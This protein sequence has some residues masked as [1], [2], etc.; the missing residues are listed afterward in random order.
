MAHQAE[1]LR[2]LA[3]AAAAQQRTYHLARAITLLRQNAMARTLAEKR[4]EAEQQLQQMREESKGLADALLQVEYERELLRLRVEQTRRERDE[5]SRVSSEEALAAAAIPAAAQQSD[6]DAAAVTQAR[7]EAEAVEAQL[8]KL[9]ERRSRAEED[10]ERMWR[11]LLAI[12]DNR[13]H[14]K[15][16][17]GAQSGGASATPPEDTRAVNAQIAAVTVAAAGAREAQKLLASETAE[18]RAHLIGVRQQLQELHGVAVEL[19]PQVAAVLNGVVR[20]LSAA[21]DACSAAQ[22]AQQRQRLAA[23]NTTVAGAMDQLRRWQ[24]GDQGGS[25]AEHEVRNT[26]AR[27]MASDAHAQLEELRRTQR[28]TQQQIEAAES[29]LTQLNR[30]QKEAQQRVGAAQDELDRLRDADAARAVELADERRKADTAQE[31][32]IAAVTAREEAETQLAGARADLS[33]AQAELKKVST[34]APAVQAR[35]AVEQEATEAAQRDLARAQQVCSELDGELTAAGEQLLEAEAQLAEVRKAAEAV[36][37][38][39]GEQQEAAKTARGDLVEAEQQRQQLEGE[40]SAARASL[41]AAETQVKKTRAEAE[42]QQQAAEREVAAA[43]AARE[44]LTAARAEVAAAEAELTQLPAA[45]AAARTQAQQQ[46]QA[47]QDALAVVEQERERMEGELA[48]ARD[49]LLTATTQLQ[50]VQAQRSAVE[51]Q[52]VAANAELASASGRLSTAQAQLKKAEERRKVVCKQAA[53]QE[54]MIAAAE[55]KLARLQEMLAEQQRRINKAHVTAA[56]Q[57]ASATHN[58]DP[59]TVN[60]QGGAAGGAVPAAAA[61][62]AAAV[63]QQQIAP[64]HT[65]TVDSAGDQQVVLPQAAAVQALA[66]THG[67]TQTDSAGTHGPTTV[68]ER[69]AQGKAVTKYSKR[70]AAVTRASQAAAAKRPR[71]DKRT[72]TASGDVDFDVVDLTMDDSS[73]ETQQLPRTS[74]GAGQNDQGHRAAGDGGAEL[75]RLGSESAEAG[76]CSAAH[77]N[78]A[79][80]LQACEAETGRKSD[81]GNGGGS[82]G[83]G[84]GD[85]SG[86]GGAARKAAG[87]TGRGSGSGDGGNGIAKTMAGA[88]KVSAAPQRQGGAPGKKRKA[89]KQPPVKIVKATTLSFL[90]LR[91]TPLRAAAAVLGRTPLPVA[92][93]A[94]LMGAAVAVAAAA[95]AAATA[96]ASAAATATASAAA[97]AAAAKAIVTG[98]FVQTAQLQL[99]ML[100]H[101]LRKNTGGVSSSGNEPGAVKTRG[102]TCSPADAAAG[103]SAD[104]AEP[105]VQGDLEVLAKQAAKAQARIK[106]HSRLDTYQKFAVV[107]RRLGALLKRHG[108]MRYEFSEEDITAVAACMGV[109][110]TSIMYEFTPASPAVPILEGGEATYPGLSLHEH[111]GPGV[112][113]LQRGWLVHHELIP[114]KRPRPL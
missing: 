58:S 34:A 97:T 6:I 104:G 37:K 27:Q 46:R 81:S 96:T 48:A 42:E 100:S 49:A 31:E 19:R 78:N 72:V 25:A 44:Q 82:D 50:D 14:L 55:A 12:T 71:N 13:V 22:L 77:N 94:V 106:G 79:V 63:A 9:R 92:V 65:A 43:V 52:V 87:R 109:A 47:A 35:M 86:D 105:E 36:R 99:Q 20:E 61:P 113:L 68:P 1:Q 85:S 107:L 83:G 33:T 41:A 38:Q 84:G 60:V 21:L 7:N 112:S 2:S 67:V 30:Q 54:E 56:A 53:L 18:T 16:K 103:G 10:R 8:Q 26:Q 93:A 80:Q 59:Q 101:K 88:G 3:D 98:A 28:A 39:A 51:A 76:A 74:S 73:G 64:A 75:E 4:T 32:L 15:Q 114:E 45:A 91:K 89:A 95:A 5:L 62:A 69:R 24:G 57:V 23:A 11:E 29:A 17:L 110:E 108:R 70:S 102:A 66:P 90:F 40:V 111:L